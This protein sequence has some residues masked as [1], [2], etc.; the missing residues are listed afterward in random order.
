[1]E[2]WGDYLYWVIAWGLWLVVVYTTSRIAGK[3]WF[4]SK[5]EQ[6]ERSF[7]RNG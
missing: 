6:E 4:K 2:G 5:T 3:A 1:M 7:Y